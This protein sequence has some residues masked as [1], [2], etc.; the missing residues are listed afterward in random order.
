MD[1]IFDTFPPLY[2]WSLNYISPRKI[3]N[4]YKKPSKQVIVKQA[5]EIHAFVRNTLTF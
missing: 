2:S 1:I 5:E 4:P 3:L